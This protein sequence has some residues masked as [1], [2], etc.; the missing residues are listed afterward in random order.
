LFTVTKT[1][2]DVSLG[3]MN[4]SMEDVAS[5]MVAEVPLIVILFFDSVVLK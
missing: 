2:P 5:V 4:V 3:A 1:G